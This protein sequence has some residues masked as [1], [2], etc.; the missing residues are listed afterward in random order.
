VKIIHRGL[1]A[2]LAAIACGTAPAGAA[3][4][5]STTATLTVN[6]SISNNCTLTNGTIAFGNYDPVVANATSPL[7]ASGTFTIACTK[8]D[9]VTIS[10]NAGTNG[11]NAPAGVTRAMAS[12]ANYLGYELYTTGARS[13]VWNASTG[14]VAYNSASR[15]P[16]TQTIYAQVPAGQDLPASASYSDTVTIT[17]SF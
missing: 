12:G 14:T 8:G 4:A 1:V 3:A 15:L 2:A 6:G 16:I 5:G 17:A 10:L 11:A 13:T 9:A 7:Q